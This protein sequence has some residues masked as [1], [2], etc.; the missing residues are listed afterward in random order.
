MGTDRQNLT[1][2]SSNVANAIERPDI[3]VAE[4]G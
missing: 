2:R 3:V 4:D 1:T